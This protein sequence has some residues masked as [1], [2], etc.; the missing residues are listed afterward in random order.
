MD[1]GEVVGGAF[2]VAGGDTAL[3]FET[4]DQALHPVALA[5]GGLVEVGLAPLAF[6][7]W[8]HGPDA[9]AA[10]AVPCRW[11]GVAL[12]AR[13]APRPQARSTRDAIR[14]ELSS[15]THR[16]YPDHPEAVDMVEHVPG[17]AVL[18]L[19]VISIRLCRQG[20]I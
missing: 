18:R 2:L 16:K 17:A 13:H 1:H 14:G 19:L 20:W 9:A 12:V 10:Q 3:L 11:A 7:G 15:A 4:V 6:P 8:D 5:V